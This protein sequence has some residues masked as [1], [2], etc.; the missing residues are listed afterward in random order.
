MKTF[1][2]AVAVGALLAGCTYRSDTTV[3]R[4]TAQPATVVVPDSAPPGSTTT[5]YV[6]ARG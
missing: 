5:V 3:Q 6:P 1:I 2:L 4:P